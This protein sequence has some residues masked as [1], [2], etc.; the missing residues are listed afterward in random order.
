MINARSHLRC[1]LIFDEHIHCDPWTCI[2]AF[3][4]THANWY[5]TC[6]ILITFT[7]H[8]HRHFI[9]TE[10]DMLYYNLFICS[11]LLFLFLPSSTNIQWWH[12]LFHHWCCNYA[13]LYTYIGIQKWSVLNCYLDIRDASCHNSQFLRRLFCGIFTAWWSSP[14]SQFHSN[15]NDVLS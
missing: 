8:C 1:C 14:C 12:L 6:A 7:Y 10:I 4:R 3:T 13:Y 5:S 9:G 15:V 11:P 2:V